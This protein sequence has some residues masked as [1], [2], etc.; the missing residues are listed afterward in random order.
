MYFGVHMAKG[1]FFSNANLAINQMIVINQNGDLQVVTIGESLPEGVVIIQRGDEITADNEPT[2]HFIGSNNELQDITDD[3]AQIFSAL[4]NG[5]DPTLLD[6]QFS[7]AAGSQG[8]APTDLATIELVSPQTIA[9]TDFS[10]VG[11]ESLGL[12]KTQS[13]ALFNLTQFTGASV[14]NSTPKAKKDIAITDEDTGVT[15]DVLQNDTDKDGDTLQVTAVNAEHGSVTVNED[16]SLYYVP[17]ANYNGQ[18]TITYTISDG[19][20]GFDTTTVIVTVNPVDDA[21]IIS[22]ANTQIDEN[23]VTVSGSLTASDVDNPSLAFVENDQIT[24]QFGYLSVDANGN[25]TYTLTGDMD[26]LAEGD[27]A[28]DVIT[29]TLNDGST[30]T[31]AVDIIGTDDAP[32]ISAA[33]TQIDENGV[34]VSGSLTASDVDNP[35][36]A[37]VEDEQITGQF[38]YLSVDADGNWTYT[39]TGDMDYLADGDSASDV[40][41]VTLNDGSSTT[42]TV[43]FIGT[44]DAPVISAANTQ[45]DENGVTV[46]GSLTAS[47]VDNPLL[48]FVENDQITGQFGY[49]SV[50]ADGNWTYTLTGDMDYLADGDSV[51]DVITVTLND[52][53]TTTVTVDIIGTDDVPIISSDHVLIDEDRD[54]VSGSLS[55]EDI[56]NPSLAFVADNHIQG[57]YGYLSIDSAGNWTYTL[58]SDMN[59]LPEGAEK[60]DIITVVLDDGSS[61]TVTVDIQ[62]VNDD[63]IAFNDENA[64]IFSDSPLVSGN[65]L[66]NDTDIDTNHDDLVVTK[67]NYD[68][69]DYNVDSE[70]GVSISTPSGVLQINSDGSYSFEAYPNHTSSNVNLSDYIDGSASDNKVTIYGITSGDYTNSDGSIIVGTN[71]LENNVNSN[72]SGIGVG[73][74]NSASKLDKGE[75]LIVQLDAAASEVTFGLS[76]ADSNEVS[77]TVFDI[78]GNPISPENYS[79]QYTYIGNSS[80]VS[81]ITIT[82]DNG[83]IGYV[84][85][86]VDEDSS[87]NSFYRVESDASITYGNQA[88]TSF[89]EDFTYTVEDGQGGSDDATLSITSNG[90]NYIN[91]VGSNYNDAIHGLNSDEHIEGLGAQDH[92]T[93]GAGNDWLDGGD[94]DDSLAG[95]GGN[96]FLVGGTGQDL[97]SGGSGN[98]SL[99]GNQ[100]GDSLAGDLGDDNLYGGQ[101]QDYLYGG[102]GNDILVGNADDDFLFG[103]SGNDVLNGSDGHDRLVG[104]DGNDTFIVGEPDSSDVI[105]DFNIAEDAL[106]I[107]ELLDIN[108]NS[109]D[110][111]AIQ[112]YLDSNVSLSTNGDNGNGVLSIAGMGNTTMFSD[113]S[114]MA[115]SDM[116]S[117]IF[118]H[119]EYSLTIKES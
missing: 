78:D 20:G 62:G 51:S 94:G 33:N 108:T 35:L 68:G 88:D 22:T 69:I 13:L 27:S 65:V 43:D 107:S 97:L 4:E 79:Y 67:V 86:E 38:G 56:D 71:E 116:V 14:E 8:S 49:L 40:I 76:Q 119:Q 19:N 17:D 103:D 25:W 55:A 85:F 92:L 42:V 47:D 115:S 80:N 112:A 74:G 109:M 5:Q 26:Y 7:P 11:F 1:S 15:I 111:E 52:G 98:D 30:T 46:S 36:L 117:V 12:S 93:G 50:D 66:D 16:G 113:I 70:S 73:S 64:V 45:I 72:S 2:V 110:H 101:G 18:D 48:A 28:S 34:T 87:N 32:V 39:L 60:E 21:P 96:D 84:V 6:E 24:G 3:I 61:T 89:E 37:F 99:Y 77:I 102:L 75:A 53:S 81:G 95:G 29:V 106:D 31:V 54:T 63:P 91:I 118:Q 44:D 83:D 104:G 90:S 100:G 10:T 59:H 114:H 58:T 105:V 57:Q 9:T 41:T 23:G 82:S